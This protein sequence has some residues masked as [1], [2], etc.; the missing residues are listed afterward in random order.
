MKEKIAKL[1]NVFIGLIVGSVLPVIGFYLSYLVKARNGIV[2]LSA[3]TD[4]AFSN[5][6]AQ[7]DILIF[8]LIPNMFMFYFSNFRWQINQFTKGL[9]AITIVLLVI[10]ILLTY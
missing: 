5:S 1:D 4:L 10:L 9:V 8:C 6:M 2:D 7:Q 3:Y